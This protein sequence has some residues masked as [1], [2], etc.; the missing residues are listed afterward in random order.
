MTTY[1]GRNYA[2]AL[3]DLAAETSSTAS[4]ERDLRAARDAL[5]SDR[6]VRAFLSNRLISRATK[7]NLVRAGLQGNVDELLVTFLFLVVDRG[8]TSFLG[9]ICEEFERLCRLAHGV[10]KVTVSSAFPLGAE[11]KTLI[12]RSLEKRL[13][14][15][16]ELQTE[17][18]PSLIGGVV[19]VSE[20]QEIEFSIEGR[21]RDLAGH[22]A[23]IGT[24]HPGAGIDER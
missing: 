14:A 4:L 5:W 15:V 8:R 11:E 6:E 18:R 10:R 20:G 12:T 9:E 3:F 7:K 24:G 17:V 16:V 2:R 21:L 22:M 1:V 23:D 19:A 13:S